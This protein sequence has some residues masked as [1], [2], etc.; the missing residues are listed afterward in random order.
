MAI[1]SCEALPVVLQKLL[2]IGNCLNAGEV[3]FGRA[4]GYDAVLL[5]EQY[6]LAMKPKTADGKMHLGE[7]LKTKEISEDDRDHFTYLVKVLK[8]PGGNPWTTPKEETDDV[9][10]GDMQKDSGDIG[11]HVA[12][13]EK[14]LVVAVQTQSE[15]MPTAKKTQRDALQASDAIFTGHRDLVDQMDA[16]IQS[17]R[18]TC[19]GVHSFLMHTPPEKKKY[20]V[21]RVLA[22]FAS[23]AK[24]LEG[25][26]PKRAQRAASKSQAVSRRCA[27]PDSD[28]SPMAAQYSTRRGRDSPRVKRR[29]G[30]ATAL[31]SMGFDVSALPGFEPAPESPRSPIRRSST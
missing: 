28:A 10:L 5:L 19:Q 13:L 29:Q 30:G 20:C 16:R 23:L 7:Y 4:D 2:F 27:R 8:T 3:A 1:L 26:P 31:Q 15:L 24:M 17:L 25:P 22:A 14:N 9:D 18:E 21:G 6:I 12:A 11:R